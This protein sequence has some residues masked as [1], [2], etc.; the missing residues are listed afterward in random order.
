MAAC[1]PFFLPKHGITFLAGTKKR[2]SYY[3]F[4]T[5]ALMI[6]GVFHLIGHFLLAPH[7]SLVSN[8]TGMLPSNETEQRLLEMMNNYHRNIGGSW[9]SMMDVQNGLSLWYS[10]S[11]LWQSA[12][13]ALLL[14]ATLPKISL[15]KLSMVNCICLIIGAL[16]SG[17]YFFWFPAVSA[18]VPATLFFLAYSQLKRQHDSVKE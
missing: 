17:C 16:I 11:F 18:L 2:M 7:L 15:A 12:L 13:C 14:T 4:G 1:H 8:F 9:M 5:Y 6:I 3:R 10:L